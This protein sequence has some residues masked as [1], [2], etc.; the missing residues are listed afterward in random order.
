MPEVCKVG[1]RGAGCEGGGWD[2][3]SSGTKY[4]ILIRDQ[5][6]ILEVFQAAS[7]CLADRFKTEQFGELYTYSLLKEIWTMSTTPA[8]FLLPY[9]SWSQWSLSTDSPEPSGNKEE[10]QQKEMNL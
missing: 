5:F 3:V 4:H 8:L 6:L 7:F 1:G 9:K 10:K 2:G